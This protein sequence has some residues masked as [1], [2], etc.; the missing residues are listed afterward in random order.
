MPTFSPVAFSSF[1][2][3]CFIS[4]VVLRCNLDFDSDTAVDQNIDIVITHNDSF[5]TNLNTL[6]HFCCCAAAE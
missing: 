3:L 1:K 2:Q 4:L 5:V 6:L